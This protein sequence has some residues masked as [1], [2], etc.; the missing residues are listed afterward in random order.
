MS[1]LDSVN[2]KARSRVELLEF[3]L[4]VLVGWMNLKDVGEIV[5]WVILML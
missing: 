4:L 2:W 3:V 1:G 5:S